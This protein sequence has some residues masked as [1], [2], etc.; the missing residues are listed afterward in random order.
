[1]ANPIHDPHYQIFRRML[2]NA[3]LSKGF[4][5]AELADVLRKNQSYVSKFERGERRL[6]FTEFVDVANALNLDVAVFVDQYKAEIKVQTLI[7]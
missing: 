3:R 1:M 7:K 2:V 4:L 5:Q 6:D